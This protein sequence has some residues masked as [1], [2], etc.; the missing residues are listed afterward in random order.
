M[1]ADESLWDPAE[2]AFVSRALQSAMAKMQQMV[3]S[4]HH[5][6]PAP[7]PEASPLPPPPDQAQ[8]TP[9]Q[10]PPRPSQAAS[11]PPAAP[12]PQDPLRAL[13]AGRP[14]LKRGEG[15]GGAGGA[16]A[17]GGRGPSPGRGR[18][19]GPSSRGPSLTG[20]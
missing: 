13:V 1:F 20:A 9:A 18:G 14:F 6:Q 3:R 8:S 12:P 2:A 11:P 16:A 17:A 19:G 15:R 5:E 4:A 7:A 10:L